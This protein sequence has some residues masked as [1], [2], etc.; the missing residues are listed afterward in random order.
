MIE[1]NLLFPELDQNPTSVAAVFDNDEDYWLGKGKGSQAEQGRFGAIANRLEKLVVARGGD[2]GAADAFRA[3]YS[4]LSQLATHPRWSALRTEFDDD[5]LRLKT[6][7][8]WHPNACRAALGGALI[9]ARTNLRYLRQ[10]VGPSPDAEAWLA[11]SDKTVSDTKAWVDQQVAE[12]RA[13]QI[14]RGPAS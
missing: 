4:V 2:P 3:M 14:T 7:P 11:R 13:D 6:G 10:F 1:D 8:E 9:H 12:G 5:G